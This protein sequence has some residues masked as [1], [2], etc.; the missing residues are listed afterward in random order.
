[1]K[2]YTDP[3]RPFVRNVTHLASLDQAEQGRR[4]RRVLCTQATEDA[5]PRRSKGARSEIQ[6]A[7]S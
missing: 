7:H 5:A 1:M 6:A 3:R 2:S 4:E